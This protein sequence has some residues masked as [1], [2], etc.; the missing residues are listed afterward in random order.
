MSH[1]MNQCNQCKS[2]FEITDEDRKFYEKL[3]VPEPKLC[4]PCRSQ[5][6]LTFRNE[7]SIYKRKCDLS[8]KDIIA[9]Y[10]HDSPF[11]VYGPEVWFTDQWDA[12]EF[13]QDF[14]FSRPFFEQFAEL[15]K[16]APRIGQVVVNVENCP[17]VNQCWWDKNCY[18]CFDVG[19]AEDCL[20]CGSTYH[21]KNVVDCSFVRNGEISY[22]LTDCTKCFNS[23]YL[24]D[25]NNCSDAFFSYDCNNCHNIAFCFNLRNKKNYVFNKQVTEDEFK[26]IMGDIK[27]GSFSKWK[28]YVKKFH[29]DVLL[30]AIHKL[31]HNINAENCSGDYIM[32]SRNCQHC[33]DCEKSEELRYCTRADERL[34]TSMD[35][36]NASIA[37]LCYDSMCAAG[38]NIRFNLSSFHPSNSNFLYCDI[39]M[40]CSDC[41]GC[42]GL[43]NKKYCILNKEYSKEEYE[44]LVPKIIDHMRKTGEWGEFFPVSLSTF[45][46]NETLAQEYFPL[47]KDEAISK[48]FKWKDPEQKE[49]QSQTCKIPDNIKDFSNSAMQEILACEDCGKNYKI[50]L[51]ELKFYR[52]MSL[53]IPH[54][55]HDCRHKDR[56]ALR[57]PRKLYNRKCDKCQKPIQ[58]T[59]S[60]DRPEKV[61]CE[62][63]YLKTVY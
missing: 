51:Q 16:R 24:Q 40:S 2:S 5:R 59:Y 13:G 26:K 53:P 4:P 9:I 63:C 20:F 55:C 61:Y 42:I 41:F 19:F 33:Y 8:G 3:D 49:Y 35:V 11:T 32:N 54:K 30:K 52:E 7:R 31:N 27:S 21:S 17:Y 29:K 46:Y 34:I 57:N 12:T 36:D 60:P 15:Q 44:K 37:E 48:G 38:H 58:T 22:F 23:I 1:N 18:L 6:R 43:R 45:A 25:C 39:M 47:S 50:I 62:S 28:E 14:D 56:M 10:P